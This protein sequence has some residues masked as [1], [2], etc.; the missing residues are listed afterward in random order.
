MQT[1]IPGTEI[2]YEPDYRQAIANS[3]P[4]S[5]DDSHSKADWDW[6]YDISTQEL[7]TKILEGIEPQYKTNLHQSFSIDRKVRTQV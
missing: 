4:R 3:W 5:I 7:A 2:E 6:T 1:L